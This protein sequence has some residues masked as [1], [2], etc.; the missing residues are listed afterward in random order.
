MKEKEVMEKDTENS[1]AVEASDLNLQEKKFPGKNLIKVEKLMSKIALNMAEFSGDVDGELDL[2]GEVFD[3]IARTERNRSE[4]SWL[5]N[6]IERMS[7]KEKTVE[8]VMAEDFINEYE[9]SIND[10]FDK[11]DDA[12][13]MDMLLYS[14]PLVQQDVSVLNLNTLLKLRGE[15]GIHITKYQKNDGESYNMAM[16]CKKKKI[17]VIK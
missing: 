8:Y 5:F 7:E 12:N 13:G 2:A 4:S 3:E 15:N 17:K 14:G 11:L 1:G 6:E 16:V 9:E 10:F